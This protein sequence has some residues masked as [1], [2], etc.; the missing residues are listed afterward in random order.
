MARVDEGFRS[1]T[2]RDDDLGSPSSP[3]A[4]CSDR[5]GSRE[6]SAAFRSPETL[7]DAVE[8]LLLAGIDRADIDVLGDATTVERQRGDISTRSEKNADA[9][10]TSRRAFLDWADVGVT[11]S[12]VAGVSSFFCAA[13]AAHYVIASGGN[14][15]AAT[16]AAMVSALVGGGICTRLAYCWLKARL[17]WE[18][19]SRIADKGIVISVR[20]R[21]PEK[22]AAAVKILKA[23][24]AE[25]VHTHECDM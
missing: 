1:G 6:V 11:L 24:G 4:K 3:P 23:H 8:E 13:A 14:S 25:A 17:P 12:V 19:D 9:S 5:V 15:V 2:A 22:E 16:A 21:S 20:L 10:A 7:E 18:Q